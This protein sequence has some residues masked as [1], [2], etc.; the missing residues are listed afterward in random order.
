MRQ[1]FYPERPVR[2]S[3]PRPSEVPALFSEG[4][5]PEP[6]R[7]TVAGWPKTLALRLLDAA[8]SLA[9]RKQA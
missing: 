2:F 5:E 4:V 8:R 7:R 3:L 9:E 1:E 6:G